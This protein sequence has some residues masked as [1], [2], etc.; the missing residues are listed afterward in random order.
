MLSECWPLKT[1]QQ[2]QPLFQACALYLKQGLAKHQGN[3][4][5]QGMQR[6][7]YSRRGCNLGSTHR[8]Q[9]IP[10]WKDKECQLHKAREIM[11]THPPEKGT[12]LL[13]PPDLCMTQLSGL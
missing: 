6:L 2:W 1:W 10:E 3:S 4:L 7:S 11:F 12:K 9:Q 13:K 5:H 8:L